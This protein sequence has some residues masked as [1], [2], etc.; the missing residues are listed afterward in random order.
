MY[1]KV[2]R[3]GTAA[4]EAGRIAIAAESANRTMKA[5]A[6]DFVLFLE[7]SNLFTCFKD[8]CNFLFL[9]CFFCLNFS[10]SKQRVPFKAVFNIC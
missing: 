4:D 6:D 9:L 7:E 5:I 3:V 1:A 10:L 2:S 8:V